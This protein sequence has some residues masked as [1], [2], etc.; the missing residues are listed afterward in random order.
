[1]YL[2]KQLY[3]KYLFNNLIQLN[4]CHKNSLI[5]E[6]S[7]YVKSTYEIIFIINK[8]KLLKEK[9]ITDIPN[10][11]SRRKPLHHAS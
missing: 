10:Y 5:F 3:I 7:I 4:K 6:L 1:M 2:Y 8:I 11:P 9:K